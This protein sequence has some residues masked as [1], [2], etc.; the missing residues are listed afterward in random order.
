MIQVSE[1]VIDSFIKTSCIIRLARLRYCKLSYALKAARRMLN[2]DP[3]RK[4]FIEQ[5]VAT[6]V[7]SG[8]WGSKPSVIVKPCEA[9]YPTCKGH[10]TSKTATVCIKCRYRWYKERKANASIDSISPS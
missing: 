3:T 8:W 2:V 6:R 7:T 1:L 10:T 9:R 5:A 4:L